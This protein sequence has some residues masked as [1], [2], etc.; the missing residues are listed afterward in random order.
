MEWDNDESTVTLHN[1]VLDDDVFLDATEYPEEDSPGPMNRNVAR[2]SANDDI[3]DDDNEDADN[4]DDDNVDVYIPDEQDDDDDESQPNDVEDDRISART[5][6]S[7][8][9]RSP[10]VFQRQN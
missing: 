4:D 8:S 3:D 9:D 7:C 10:E 6:S 2:D 1:S 5:R